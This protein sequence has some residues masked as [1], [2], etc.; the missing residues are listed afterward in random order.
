MST[1]LTTTPRWWLPAGLV[2]LG[3]VV[4]AS[5]MFGVRGIAP[6]EVWQAL[7]EPVAGNAD[8]QVVLDLR[9]PRTLVGLLAG[10]ALGLAGTMIQGVTRNPIADPGL[11]GINAGAALAVVLSIWLLGL[12]SAGQF[13]WFAF[14]GAAAAA[15][16]VAAI[17]RGDPIRLV[18]G[19]AALTAFLTPLVTLVLMRSSIAF[20]QYRF[21]AVG[22]LTGRELD[23]VADLWPFV[24]VGSAIAFGVAHRLDLLALGD[25]V[26]RGLGQRVGVT[27]ALAG[28][29]IT[30]LAGAATSLVGPIALVGLVVPHAARRLVGS[31]YRRMTA[32]AVALGPAIL[33]TADVIGRL[34][35]RPGELEAGV[36]SALIG[37]PVLIAVA[38][39][40]RVAGV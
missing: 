29:G 32:L 6:I 1:A 5:L 28:A 24:A 25:D 3:V 9:V 21:W 39:G 15:V 31:D 26:A 40:R 38:R 10:V 2:A 12:T 35:A 27:R 8:H 11:L 30:I 37:A 23:L 7:V 36:V 17:G 16:A 20:D 4:V 34:V 22:A 14:A 18:L 19:G 13:V 33:L